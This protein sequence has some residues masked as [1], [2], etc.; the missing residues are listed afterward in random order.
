V[1]VELAAD[2]LVGRQDGLD[3]LD[4]RVAVQ[5]ELGQHALVAQRAE[6]D[7]LGARHVQRLEAGARDAIEQP[8]RAFGRGITLQDDDHMWCLS[9]LERGR[10][11]SPPEASRGKS[12]ALLGGEMP[13]SYAG[14]PWGAGTSQRHQRPDARAVTA[15]VSEGKGERICIALL[16]TRGA[17]AGQAEARSPHAIG[18]PARRRPNSPD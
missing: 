6:H 16:G 13:R 9:S 12:G 10:K 2:E 17:L 11:K 5:R 4:V 14:A 8:L 7:A 15:A 3:R 1:G 18:H